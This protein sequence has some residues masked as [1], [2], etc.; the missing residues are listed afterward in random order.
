M[1]TA[2]LLPLVLLIGMGALWGVTQPL[3][4]IAVLAG[5]RDIGIIFW[6]CALGAAFLGVLNLL[7][8]GALPLHRRALVFY[9]FIALIGTVVPNSASFTAAIHLPSG[10]MSIVLATVPM[11]AFPIA[12]ALGM[13]RF[14]ALRLIGLLL[15]LG[16]II[17]LAAP[18]GS[19]PD[20]ALAIW[21]PLAMVAPLLYAVEA[22]VVGK[23]GT[24]G[25]DAVQVLLGASLVGMCIAGPLALAT[26]TW[27]DPTGPRDA[28]FWAIIG[29]A[30][31]HTTAY[32]TYVWLVG[33]TGA[34][35]ASQ[36]GY[37]VTGFGV[38]W[39]RLILGESY[40]PWVWAALALMLVGV[41]LVQPRRAVA[42]VVPL[43][44]GI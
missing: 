34:V 23:W 10:I 33:R 12:I 36:V 28:G 3:T 24:V 9:L 11:F 32:T 25:L 13:D 29:I 39:A 38:L 43:E 31:A 20:P 22:N 17:L 7:R 44:E 42:A 27:V 2:R 5:H 35:F 16:A 41:F 26:G 1:T 37:L 18:R 40:S 19:L 4:K 6:Q 21:L 14:S 8:G 15:G 30:L